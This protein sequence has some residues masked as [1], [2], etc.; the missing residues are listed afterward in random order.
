MRTP[1]HKTSR[2]KALLGVAGLPAALT[3]LL[4]CLSPASAGQVNVINPGGISGILPPIL[5]P[6]P[7]PP[8]P[9][10]PAPDPGS[11]GGAPP[12][13]PE[14]GSAGGGASNEAGPSPDAA[15]SQFSRAQTEAFAQFQAV[16]LG[17]LSVSSLQTARS[18]L[19]AAL[20]ALPSGSPLR[21]A[22][23]AELARVEGEL[24][25]RG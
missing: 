22:L 12:S 23:E 20:E 3:L 19:L 1:T 16:P 25:R 15:A 13:A 6:P 7:P 10:G 11:G 2:A 4:V 18:I 17:T 21:A 9:P 8:P 24:Q 14:G 5:P